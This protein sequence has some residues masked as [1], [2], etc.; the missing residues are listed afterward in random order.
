MSEL[1][2]S[3]ESAVKDL[4]STIDQSD[5]TPDGEVP[6]GWRWARIRDVASYVSRGIGPQYVDFGGVL[7]INQKCIRDGGLDLDKARRH[8]TE[9]RSV[10]GRQLQDGDMLINSTGVGTLGRVA[11]V[12]GIS[13]PMIVDGHVTVVR[14]NPKLVN[15]DYFAAYLL[16]REAEIE[17][18]GEGTTGQT[19]LSKQQVLDFPILLPPAN[20]QSIIGAAARRSAELLQTLQAERKLVVDLMFNVYS[21]VAFA[22][23]GGVPEPAE[24]GKSTLG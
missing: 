23:F 22:K 6:H 1:S 24:T 5:Q 8:D 2:V 3:L 10:D 15:R 14:P 4:T 12:V 11:Q 19:E 7:V 20:L 13:E 9:K 17:E 18:L 21:A 16:S